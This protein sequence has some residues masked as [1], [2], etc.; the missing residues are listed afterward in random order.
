MSTVF[1][2]IGLIL[3]FFFASAL[4]KFSGFLVRKSRI[5]WK[6]SCI[7]AA[8]LFIGTI[9]LGIVRKIIPLEIPIPVN[10]A[11]SVCLEALLAS[12]YFGNRAVDQS[13]IAIGSRRA[14]FVGGTVF[15]LGMVGAIVLVAI[16]TVLQ[17]P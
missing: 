2:L 7:F 17:L 15:A 11:I 14:A 9:A 6:H 13:G 8:M 1:F 5:S 3:I 10:I 12:A 4:V 16:R